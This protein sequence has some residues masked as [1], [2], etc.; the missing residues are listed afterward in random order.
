MSATTEVKKRT[1]L[2]RAELDKKAA[3][4]KLTKRAVAA[5]AALSENNFDCNHEKVVAPM[6][7]LVGCEP[8]DLSG[9][10]KDRNVDFV[11]GAAVKVTDAGLANEADISRNEVV[12]IGCLDGDGDARFVRRG[13]KK[14]EDAYLET[15]WGNNIKAA[16]DA[17]IDRFFAGF[18]GLLYIS[19]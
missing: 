14:V 9:K 3:P 18:K 11:I 10:Q 15:N 16:T 5:K 8:E 4:S 13:D 6:A 12:L 19:A 1:A 7:A 17:E 2:M